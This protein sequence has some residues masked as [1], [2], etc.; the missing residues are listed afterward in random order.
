MTIVV[1]AT[2]NSGKHR[3]IASKLAQHNID[4]R[5]QTDFNVRPAEETGTTFVENAI[6]KARHASYI[7]G[8]PALADDSGLIVPSLSGNPG[9][10][11]S[12]YAGQDA[13]DKQNLEKL[14]IDMAY[15]ENRQAFFYCVLVLM[16]HAEDPT[17]LICEGRWH[18]T[19]TR[20]PSGDDGFGYDPIFYVPEY[21]CTSAQ[22]SL[23]QKN[24]LSHR[25]QALAKLIDNWPI[26]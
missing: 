17:P 12:R 8:Q 14:L 25:G 3:E 20:A 13:T 6:I 11:S 1:L 16:T 19:I 23:E 22:L 9:V 21:Q 10:Y 5:L 4:L 7:S 15:I 2:G 24:Q 26:T 18:G